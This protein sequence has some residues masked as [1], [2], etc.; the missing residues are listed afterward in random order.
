MKAHLYNKN[1]LLSIVKLS[2]Y[3]I[4]GGFIVASISILLFPSADSH[5]APTGNRLAT[6]DDCTQGGGT[7]GATTEGTS[8]GCTGGSYAKA[9]T[10]D[11]Q[12]KSLLYYR[13][14]GACFV[15]NDMTIAADDGVSGKWFDSGE[16]IAGAYLRGS[17]SKGEGGEPK[18]ACSVAN[19]VVKPALSLW[20]WS[21]TNQAL[22]DFGWVR[23]NKT[24]CLASAGGSGNFKPGNSN[25]T[26]AE[27][28]HDSVKSYIYGLRSN[29]TI[30]LPGAAW[31]TF[32]LRTFKQSCAIGSTGATTQPS[33]FNTSSPESKAYEIKELVNGTTLQ[34]TY[35][36]NTAQPR[37][38]SLYTRVGPEY[39]YNPV[40][41][42]CADIEGQIN[43]YAPTFLQ[44]ASAHPGQV[45]AVL[46]QA[47]NNT[48]GSS[49]NETTSCSVEGIGWI[50]CPVAN[51]LAGMADFAFDVVSAFMKVEPL[52]LSPTDNPLYSAWST[53][54]SIA[55]VAFVI[56]F[57]I[58]IFSQLT[59]AGITNYG[60]KKMLPR[61]VVSAILVNISYFICALAVDLSNVLGISLQNVFTAI[62]HS[63]VSGGEEWNWSSITTSVLSLGAVGTLGAVVFTAFS[64]TSI[65]AAL[66]GLLPLVIAALFALVIAFLVLLAR[67]ALIIIL[68]VLSPL[69]FVAYLLPNTE[70]LFKKWQKL[71]T[72]LLLLFPMLSIV[73]GGS[74][75]ASSILRESARAPMAS[76]EPGTAI[77]GFFLY[78]G[79]LA[80]QAI[81]FFITPLLIKLSGG[82]LT[83]FAGLVNNPRKGPADRAAKWSEQQ[84]KNV[85]NRAYLRSLDGSKR[86][87]A[88]F[89]LGARRKARSNSVGSALEQES[90]RAETSYI[91]SAVQNS[92]GL[93]KKMAGTDNDGAMQR[94]LASAIN[95]EVKLEAEEVN[96]ASAVIRNFDREQMRTIAQG[97]AVTTENGA[98]VSGGNA[99][100]RAAAMRKVIDS[101]DIDGVN[102]LLDNA[103]NAKMTEQDRQNFAEA[104]EQS[105][106]RPGYVGFGHI[107]ALRTAKQNASGQL[108]TVDKNG[109]DVQ[110]GNSTDLT[111]TAINNNTYS[112]DKLATT[113]QEEL[114][115]VFNIASD[116]SIPTNNAQIKQNAT[117]ALTESQYAGRVAKQRKFVEAIQRL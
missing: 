71:F 64:S 35:Y 93:Q 29:Q 50:I 79:S 102:K 23:E 81:P 83:R 10:P 38:K 51:A 12:V 45:A 112:V 63:L 103:A 40:S 13:I 58:I 24:P 16:P 67:Q 57:L 47:N 97:G 49:G 77:T 98:V 56:A 7:W 100:M 99:A 96:A 43:H 21:N 106:G 1:F 37:N 87:N 111:V 107:A 75:L 22:C 36:T 109:A 11:W 74:I 105:S 84:Q 4:V 104:L 117:A 3:L 18:A 44:W 108:V 15:N 76:G 101:G 115:H 82:V 60:V 110:L 2:M 14:M 59:G 30:D 92:T 95:T 34:S 46:S 78:I 85:N 25:I 41:Q 8:L 90:R 6:Q 28:F 54:R 70:S 69:A 5:A 39:S 66:V 19:E 72:T 94:V 113:Q 52:K 62:N 17:V 73:F 114:E 31:Y 33:G 27:A 55:N 48:G 86:R 32:Y 80:V 61:L 9:Q 26:R 116:V 20:G 68:I 91:S 65:W 88:F 89:G 53:M 42:S